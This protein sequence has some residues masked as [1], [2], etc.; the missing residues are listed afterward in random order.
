MEDR[1]VV[2]F[3][4]SERLAHWLQF[5]AFSA[6]LVT[7]LFI[8]MPALQAFTVGRAGEASRVLHRISAVVFM[9]A[10]LIYLVGNPSAFFSSLRDAFSWSAD[11]R[12]WLSKAVAYYT[13]GEVSDMPPQGKYNGGQKLNAVVQIVAFV[14]FVVTGLIMWFGKGSVSPGLFAFSVILHD[15]AVIAAVSLVMLHV[16]LVTIHPLTR[17]SITAMFE[18]IVTRE[19]AQE[20][21]AKWLADVEGES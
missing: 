12:A 16:Y 11:D 4:S 14:L 5:V 15:L 19:Y 10:P 18:G 2:R 8:Y 13:N 6:L 17:E 7:G 1:Y 21:H 20:H 9:I 3:S